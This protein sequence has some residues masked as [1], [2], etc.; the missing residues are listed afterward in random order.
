MSVL[1]GIDA[2]YFQYRACFVRLLYIFVNQ[3]YKTIFWHQSIIAA[4]N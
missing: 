4:D 3:M 1:I 2:L